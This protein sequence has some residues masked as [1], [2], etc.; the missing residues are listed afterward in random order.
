M[1]QK[2]ITYLAELNAHLKKTPK[3][4]TYA[5]NF[6][7]HCMLYSLSLLG[8]YNVHY[9]T[10]SSEK[11][12]SRETNFPNLFDFRTLWEVTLEENPLV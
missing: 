11:S 5:S 3:W 1:V 12:C 7:N 4:N 2:P 9:L 6:R 8:I 10:K